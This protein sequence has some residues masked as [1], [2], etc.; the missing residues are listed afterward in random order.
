MLKLWDN[1]H[2]YHSFANSDQVKVTHLSLLLDVDFAAKQLVGQ[3]ELQLEFIDKKT[4]ELWLDSRDLL[5]EVVY[6]NGE[7]QLEY[8]IDKHDVTLGQR[9]NIQ[10]LPATQSV[11]IRY[12]TSVNAQGLQ[13]L[14]PQQTSGKSL[15]FLFSQSQPINARS[16]IPL[17]DTPKARITFDA[18]ITAPKGM[19]VV[20]SALNDAEVEL[21]GQFTFSMEKPMPTHLLAIAVG[22]LAFAKLGARTGVY[23]EPEIIDSAAI[24]FEDTESMVEVA[25][26]LLGPYPWGRYDMIVLP[27]SFPFGGMENPRLA[28]MTPTLI[29]G[30]KSLVST[31]AHEL[32]HSW[33][34]N[35]VS[36]ATWRDLW[37]NEGFTTYFT[38]RIVEAVYGKE[39]AELEV[40]LEHGRL[41]EA[42]ASTALTAQT[43]PANMQQQ[44]PNEAFNRFTYDK[45]SMF[46]HDLERRLGREAFDK[47]LF[48]YVQRFAFEAITTETFVSYAKQTLLLE[49]A[50]KITEA[51]LLEWI[52]G[53]GM[54]SWYAEPTSTS[55]DKVIMA[56]RAFDDGASAA[57]LMTQGWR[58]HHWQYFLTHLPEKLSHQALADLDNQFNFTQSTNAEIAC[59]WFRVAIRNEYQVVL[60]AVAAYLVKIGRGKFV[61]PLYAELLKAGFEVQAT[62]IYAK[63][64]EGYHPSIVVMLDQ[65]LLQ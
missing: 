62:Q 18:V 20:M 31:V 44:D 65:Q 19:R 55:L 52:Y 59:D 42:I 14:T 58:V 21:T 25:E 16:W 35:L 39:Q 47:F 27:P 36:N 48:Q 46:V 57:S 54:P 10:L 29:A 17:Q 41:Y 26:S 8:S 53:E 13:W 49:H 30:D 2:D 24:E 63:A 4:T 15:P 43:L 34:G 40:V 60:E 61:K 23:A 56:L 37:L 33:T 51:E 45:A 32:A 38:N 22:E 5:I 28:F 3:V 7:Q 12:R 6:G 50:D 1:N 9:L 64:R 11:T